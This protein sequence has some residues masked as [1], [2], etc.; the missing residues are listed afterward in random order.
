ML[1][2]FGELDRFNLRF[3]IAACDDI[4]VGRSAVIIVGCPAVSLTASLRR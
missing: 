3:V 4:V 2:H 1:I